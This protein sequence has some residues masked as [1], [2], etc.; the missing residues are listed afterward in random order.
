[1]T[2]VLAVSAVTV[3]M[4]VAASWSNSKHGPVYF[5]LLLFLEAGLFGTYSALNFLHWFL[6]WE[7]SLI[8]AFFLIRLWG[9]SARAQA[10]TQFFVYTMAGS[11]ALLLAF[12][13]LLPG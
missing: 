1:M 9:R 12:L 6:Y 8:P 11:I 2:G 7:L 10:A 4:S 5:A 13:A 3:L